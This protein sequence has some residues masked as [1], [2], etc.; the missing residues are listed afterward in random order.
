MLPV[1]REN[2]AAAAREDDQQLTLN[3]FQRTLSGIP[4]IE[5]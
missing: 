3:A 4:K 2:L 1:N 5:S